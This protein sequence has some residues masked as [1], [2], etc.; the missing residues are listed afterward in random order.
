MR[1]ALIV[2]ILA[3]TWA[4]TSQAG[5]FFVIT[6][7]FKSQ[8]D[9]QSRAASNGG[10][11]ID[12]DVYPGLEPDRYAVVR[13]PYASRSMA[14]KEL[15]ALKKIK[16]Y[17]SAYVKDAGVLRFPSNIA[18]V[19]SPKI[20]AALLG[21]LSVSVKEMAGAEGG[22]E[23]DEPYQEVTWSFVTLDRVD[24][25]KFGVDVKA[26]RVNL[27]IGAFWVIKRTGEIE[28]MRVCAE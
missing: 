18:G 15:A 1:S 28:R 24:S 17:K 11:A 3:M 19:A 6:D 21:E 12:T 10:W 22:C 13:G 5:D 8:E 20:L 26:R 7:T 14:T 16:T 27:D 4:G 2:F 9:A 25:E 23:P